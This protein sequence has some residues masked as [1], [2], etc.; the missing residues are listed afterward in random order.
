MERWGESDG[1]RPG[2]TGTPVIDVAREDL[3]GR[4]DAIRAR[5]TS[6]LATE[7]IT[8]HGL[9][10]LRDHYGLTPAETNVF[11]EYYLGQSDLALG[12]P[13]MRR[14][15]AQELNLSE[16]TLMHHITSIRSKLGLGARK[17]SATVLMWC[18]AAGIT[19]L[20]ALTPKESDLKNPGAKS[21]RGHPAHSVEPLQG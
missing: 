7:R 5:L 14:E 2:R 6:A 16:N 21:P 19:N 18:L 13:S 10:V 15:L 12:T 3:L 1:T 17:G 20:H 4:N 9:M 8:P 11:V